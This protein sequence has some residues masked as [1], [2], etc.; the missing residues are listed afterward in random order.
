MNFQNQAQSYF[1]IQLVPPS[2]E[3]IAK[4]YIGATMSHIYVLFIIL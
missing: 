4:K 2:S 1:D 3:K